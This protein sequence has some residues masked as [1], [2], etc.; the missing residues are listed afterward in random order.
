MRSWLTAAAVSTAAALLLS[1][2]AAGPAGSR[3]GTGTGTQ[4]G[5]G[6]GT[7]SW[8]NGTRAQALA[9]ARHLLAELSLPPGT[10]P[11]HVT[12][13]PPLL[14]QHQGP[15][16]GWAGAQEILVAPG[17]PSAVLERLDAH[18]PFGTP[19]RYGAVPPTWSGALLPAPERGI[20]AAQVSVGTAAEPGSRTLVV[21]Y[22]GA[23]WL[24]GRAAAEH[25]DPASFRAVAVT[26]R[27]SQ[28]VPRSR[29]VTRAVTDPAVIARLAALVNGLP[30][31]SEPAARSCAAVLTGYTVRFTAGGGSGT[32]AAA[33]STG[34]CGID[35]IS[36]NGKP[37]PG[38]WDTRDHLA[39]MA[40]ALLGR[41]ALPPAAGG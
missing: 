40:R 18:A 17:S 31:A 11:S 8:G 12:S 19:T 24:P 2:C 1:G 25:L 36:V 39:A 28:Q 4:T 3:T 16:A 37:Q 9:L 38:L 30:P 23:T 34:E 33:V 6:T 20:D 27:E 13:L 35:A 15:G 21:A 7:P 29:Q 5:T 14:R 10:K 26:E 22:A 32:V 41:A